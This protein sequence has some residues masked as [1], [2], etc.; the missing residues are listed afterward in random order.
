MNTRLRHILYIF[1]FRCNAATMLNA[2]EHTIILEN[3]ADNM[4]GVSFIESALNT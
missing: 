3:I 1:I 4:G 2:H